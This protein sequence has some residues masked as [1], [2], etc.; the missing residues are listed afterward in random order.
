MII[1]QKR[2][3]EFVG[4]IF[5]PLFEDISSKKTLLLKFKTVVILSFITS[6]NPE[7]QAPVNNGLIFG[8][9][10]VA[11]IRIQARL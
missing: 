7:Q 4:K 10:R 11:V 1:T 9:P 5:S 8:V 6:R 2:G 3:Y